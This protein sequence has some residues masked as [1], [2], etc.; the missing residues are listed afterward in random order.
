M[1]TLLGVVALIIGLPIFAFVWYQGLYDDGRRR[2]LNRLTSE[3]VIFSMVLTYLLLVLPWPGIDAIMA[4]V[5]ILT[6]VL[7]AG[8]QVLVFPRRLDRATAPTPYLDRFGFW[9][10]FFVILLFLPFVE[11]IGLVPEPAFATLAWILAGAILGQFLGVITILV[12]ERRRGEP[13]MEHRVLDPK[14]V[15]SVPDLVR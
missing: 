9:G 3:I 15:R 14:P 10:R 4:T 13:I 2:V 1:V 5:G 11:M 8:Y 7:V 6:F 12:L